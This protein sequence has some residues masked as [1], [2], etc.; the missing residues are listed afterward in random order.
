MSSR[1]VIESLQ[2]LLTEK[3]SGEWNARPLSIFNFFTKGDCSGIRLRQQTYEGFTAR[4]KH[5]IDVGRVFPIFDSD[6]LAAQIIATELAD[7]MRQAIAHWAIACGQS[8]FSVGNF[9]AE[10]PIAPLAK[11]AVQSHTRDTYAPTASTAAET[12]LPG[13]VSGY[14]IAVILSFDLEYQS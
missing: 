13:S 1:V 4:K 11:I 14:A 7:E 6:F 9:A 2:A 8:V 5:K 12:D 3:F 10:T